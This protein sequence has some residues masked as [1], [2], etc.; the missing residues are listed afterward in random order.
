MISF[1]ASFGVP[2]SFAGCLQ[3]FLETKVKPLF[4]QLHASSQRSGTSH[5]A[6]LSFGFLLPAFCKRGNFHANAI[7]IVAAFALV[8]CGTV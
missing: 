8:L 2:H 4:F 1:W 3:V 7:F 5:F 6:L